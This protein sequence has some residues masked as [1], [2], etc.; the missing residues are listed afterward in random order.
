MYNGDP[1][2]EDNF[3]GYGLKDFITINSSSGFYGGYHDLQA[4]ILIASYDPHNLP[5]FEGSQSAAYS[6]YITNIKRKAFDVNLKVTLSK[7]NGGETLIPFKSFT[8]ANSYSTTFR[9]LSPTL[10][11][12]STSAKSSST[13]VVTGSTT[14]YGGVTD[15]SFSP[16]TLLELYTYPDKIEK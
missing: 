6:G 13:R 1:S 7:E 8:N 15:V 3:V 2:N 11:I 12:S 10:S 4:K 16:E 14:T 5:D 9:D